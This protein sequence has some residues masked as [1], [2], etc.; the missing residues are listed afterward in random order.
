M[1][2]IGS[3]KYNTRGGEDDSPHKK[4]HE[5]HPDDYCIILYDI[6]YRPIKY[7]YILCRQSR[8]RFVSVPIGIRACYTP[9]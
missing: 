2:L 9:R 1:I 7:L 6:I 4:S 3:V 8:F 5:C